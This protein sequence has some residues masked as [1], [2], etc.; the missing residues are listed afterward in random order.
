MYFIASAMY[1]ETGDY[2][3]AAR[4]L[5]KTIRVGKENV[6]PERIHDYILRHAF[7]NE[8]LGLYG[9]AIENAESVIRAT[10][11]DQGR[12][13]Y[14]SSLV[15][16]LGIFVT[17]NSSRAVDVIRELG[18]AV[19]VIESKYRLGAYHRA[20]GRYYANEQ[21]SKY[22]MNEFEIARQ[23]FSEARMFDDLAETETAIASMLVTEGLVGEAEHM[24]GGAEA[25]IDKMESNELRAK[26]LSVEL[27]CC[28]KKGASDEGIR[29]YLNLCDAIRPR[30]TEVKVALDLDAEMFRGALVTGN[31]PAA[32]VAFN[33][34]FEQVRFVVSN[35]PQEY[36]SDYV[37]H[38]QL[39]QVMELYRQ[40]KTQN[41]GQR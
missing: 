31:I 9:N 29:G 3:R 14:F 27:Q 20:L 38:P 26:L 16:L 34:Y 17:I 12:Q 40:L 11:V 32:L 15:A 8:K 28:I 30:I 41:P 4:F 37:R 7:I 21:N 35:L 2:T 1:Y 39:N 24:L 33:R 36:A 25:A 18:L 10:D 6:L 5:D 19:N 13:Q 23:L 22:A